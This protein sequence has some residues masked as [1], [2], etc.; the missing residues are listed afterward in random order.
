M[1]VFC[2]S[3]SQMEFTIMYFPRICPIR[4]LIRNM[5]NLNAFVSRELVVYTAPRQVVLIT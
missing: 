3:T 5:Y 1:K 4:P 2:E